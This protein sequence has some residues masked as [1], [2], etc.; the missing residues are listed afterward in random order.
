MLNEEQKKMV[1]REYVE[2]DLV[3]TFIRKYR[4]NYDDFMD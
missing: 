4:L 3:G 2:N 1:E